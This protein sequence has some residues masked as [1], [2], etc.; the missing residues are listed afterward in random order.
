MSATTT[1]TVSS[2]TWR[3]NEEGDGYEVR[4]CFAGSDWEAYCAG[5]HPDISDAYL[6]VTDPRALGRRTLRRFARQTALERAVALG[7]S[8]SLVF[9]DR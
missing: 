4:T 2:I 7:V 3:I 5:N 8:A 1:D 6:A 9:E